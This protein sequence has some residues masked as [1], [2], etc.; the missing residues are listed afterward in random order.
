MQRRQFFQSAFAFTAGGILLA[1]P[2]QAAGSALAWH[3]DLREAHT[4]AVEHDRPMLVVF[5]AKWCKFCHKLVDEIEADRRLCAYISTNYIPVILDYDQDNR[6]AKVLEI[7][8]LPT[9][10]LLSP[11]ADLLSQKPGYMKLDAFQKLLVE[12]LSQ[13]NKTRPVQATAARP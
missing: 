11:R 3:H 7:D 10:V 9:T 5:S 2:L 13:S 6:I 4:K 12:G 1:N 8:A